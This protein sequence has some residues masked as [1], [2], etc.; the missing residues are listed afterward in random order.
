MPASFQG[1]VYASFP[2]VPADVSAAGI[3]EFR[4]LQEK[5][6]LTNRHAAAQLSTFAAAK[7]FVETLKQSG[8]DL[9]RIKL[10]NALQQVSN[11]E[12]G[13]TRPITFGPKER[14]GSRGSYIVGIDAEKKEFM[15]AIWVKSN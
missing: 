4:A 8:K 14:V 9:T 11:F 2:T 3:A 5:Y 10:V 13:V 1:K 7:L 15:S 6:K 12:T